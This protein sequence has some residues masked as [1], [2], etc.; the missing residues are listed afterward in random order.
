MRKFGQNTVGNTSKKRLPGDYGKMVSA[1]LWPLRRCPLLPLPAYL[2][3]PWPQLD[4]GVHGPASLS[5][6]RERTVVSP[7]AT[8]SPPAQAAAPL[9]D[10]TPYTQLISIRRREGK[11][12][13]CVCLFGHGCVSV[14]GGG[15]RGVGHPYGWITTP[16]YMAWREKGR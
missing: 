10:L 2:P 11:P 5:E 6:K 15:G 8:R 14:K 4:R 1:V 9:R 16:D 7:A 12:S 13:G 3:A